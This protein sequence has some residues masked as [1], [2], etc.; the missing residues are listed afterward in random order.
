[1]HSL[2]EVV[3]LLQ[4]AVRHQTSVSPVPDWHPSKIT[5]P[6]GKL[7]THHCMYR[8][9]N[10]PVPDWH[11][12]K[13]TP[14]VGKLLT[15]HCMYREDNPNPNQ[16]STIQLLHCTACTTVMQVLPPCTHLIFQHVSCFSA[17][18]GPLQVPVSAYMYS[19]IALSTSHVSIDT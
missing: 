13:I 11:P 14:P 18:V 17:P 10:P 15:H 8:E 6:V 16:A 19:G 4:G 5:P 9:D 7:L 3:S 12:S 2:W 1:M